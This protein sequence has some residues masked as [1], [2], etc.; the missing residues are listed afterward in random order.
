MIRFETVQKNLQH[1][2]T[3]SLLVLIVQIIL[4]GLRPCG[5][6]VGRYCVGTQSS[7]V[8]K[9]NFFNSAV[10]MQYLRWDLTVID[11][12]KSITQTRVLLIHFKVFS[13]KEIT[14]VCL[15]VFKSHS[16]QLCLP[17]ELS[18]LKIKCRPVLSSFNS[19][20]I[21]QGCYLSSQAYLRHY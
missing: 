12:K 17:A 7:G 15:S 11:K 5:G 4:L 21:T 14:T 3:T 16:Y 9:W 8:I 10:S 20:Y 2:S 18:K 6:F 19:S 13:R 1:Y